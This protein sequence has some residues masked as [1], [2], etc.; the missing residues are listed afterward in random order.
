M[1]GFAAETSLTASS[2]AVEAVPSLSGV[3]SSVK[4]HQLSP[5]RSSILLNSRNISPI[6]SMSSSDPTGPTKVNTPNMVNKEYPSVVD[7]AAYDSVS[8]RYIPFDFFLFR[9]ACQD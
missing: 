8:V 5:T 9:K 4:Q 6:K 1:K 2:I 7:N 3:T